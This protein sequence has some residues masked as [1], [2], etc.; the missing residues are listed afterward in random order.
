MCTFRVLITNREALAFSGS[1]CNH[2]FKLLIQQMADTSTEALALDG[3]RFILL[4]DAC[5]RAKGK[6]KL[7]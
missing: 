4:R 6:L 7:L 1:S 5:F 2:P 3:V